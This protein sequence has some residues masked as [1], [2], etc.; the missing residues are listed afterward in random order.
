MP[1]YTHVDDPQH[2]GDELERRAVFRRQRAR[3]IAVLHYDSDF[4]IIARVTGQPTEWVE[5]HGSLT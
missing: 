3:R 1:R 5:P 4:D 2:L